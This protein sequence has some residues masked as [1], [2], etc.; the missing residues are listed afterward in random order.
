MELVSQ[1]IITQKKVHSISFNYMLRTISIQQVSVIVS[2]HQLFLA[3][4]C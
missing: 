3:A 2:Q 1:H 4:E